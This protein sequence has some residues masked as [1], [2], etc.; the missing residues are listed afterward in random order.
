MKELTFTDWMRKVNGCIAG[1]T[2]GLDSNDL[3]DYNYRDCF[4]DEYTPRE[5]AL[6]VLEENGLDISYLE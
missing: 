3:S 5:V 2:G 4:D 6:E 1:I